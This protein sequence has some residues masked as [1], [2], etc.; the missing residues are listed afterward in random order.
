[1]KQNIDLAD[2]ITDAQKFLAEQTVLLY[3]CSTE[4]LEGRFADSFI[5]LASA[6]TTLSSINELAT[7]NIRYSTEILM[8]SRAA[9]EKMTN[10][11][12]V[13]ISSEEEY[14]RFTLYPFYRSYHNLKRQKFNSTDKLTIEYSHIENIKDL[15]QF[16]EAL[17]L[18]SDTNPRMKWSKAHK[19]IDEKLAFIS[20][21]AKMPSFI[22]LLNSLLI[23][24]D[25]SEALHGNLYGAT[26]ML[27][28]YEPPFTKNGA[29]ADKKIKGQLT[30]L[31]FSLGNMVNSLITWIAKN[32]LESQKIQD[33][34]EQSNASREKIFKA[35]K[36]VKQQCGVREATP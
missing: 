26:S 36:K 28:V 9:L 11:M 18:F 24:G 19:T 25:A 15:P 30:M 29:E 12:Y 3:A 8:L 23:Y 16:K 4:N 17:N 1:M 21:S 7:S 2:V 34:A 35:L 22:F 14:K 33:L 13:S 31:Y 27:G 10:Y 20:K 6:V 32:H 5:V